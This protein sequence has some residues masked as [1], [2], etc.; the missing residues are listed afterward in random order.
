[1]PKLPDLRPKAAQ[2]SFAIPSFSINAVN[3]LS[4][5]E[6]NDD[7]RHATHAIIGDD[8]E[9]R[10]I[11]GCVKLHRH[12]RLATLHRLIRKAGVC[13]PCLRANDILMEI[14][15]NQG[16]KEFG[17]DDRSKAFRQRAAEFK[18][19]VDTG[20]TV[21]TLMKKIPDLCVGDPFTIRKHVEKP[22]RKG[23]RVSLNAQLT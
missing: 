12:L 14:Q 1:M 23:S 11:Q 20:A 19:E 8:T 2:W 15:M 21:H 17:K 10:Y 16:F 4:C 13:T 22:M 7:V 9:N 18:K 3:R 5:P 6:C